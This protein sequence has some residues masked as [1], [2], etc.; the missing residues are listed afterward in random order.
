MTDDEETLMNLGVR[1]RDGLQDM[2]DCGRLK[3][4]D[5]PDDDQWLVATLL[6]M[7]ELC[8]RVKRTEDE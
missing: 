8:Q 2:L 5:I 6:D 4:D 7:A 3:L 1:L